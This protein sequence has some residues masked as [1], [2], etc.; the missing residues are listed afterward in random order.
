MAMYQAIH[1]ESSVGSNAVV[2]PLDAQMGTFSRPQA[3]TED[4]NTPL[5]PFTK[6]NGNPIISRDVSSAR[7][8]H[9]FG[10]AYPEVP[11][12]YR[13]RSDN[14]LAAFARKAAADLY[15]SNDVD[16]T[17][18]GAAIQAPS[19]TNGTA[20]S[21]PPP[22]QNSKKRTEWLATITFDASEIDDSFT[23]WIYIGE[24]LATGEELLGS[25][26]LVDG[27]SSFGGHGSMDNMLISGT[28]PLTRALTRKGVRLDPNEVVG[29]LKDNLHWKVMRGSEVFNIDN[30]S[31][32]K[33]QVNGAEVVYSN[34]SSELPVYGEWKTYYEPTA[35]KKGGSNVYRKIPLLSK[36]VVA[37]NSTSV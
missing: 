22:K 26:N 34:D 24:E 1:P 2:Q 27:C 7:S 29:Y 5:S 10:Y 11:V 30:L 21:P 32:L 6:A 35:S 3:N 28:V 36:D 25:K 19:F 23:V 31:S 14:E 18:V 8:I 16:E 37:V 12:E 20:L 17:T 9:N 15:Y 4:I 13:S 33:V